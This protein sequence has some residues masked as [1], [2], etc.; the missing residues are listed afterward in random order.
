MKQ[1]L[2]NLNRDRTSWGQVWMDSRIGEMDWNCEES[3]GRIGRDTSFHRKA[4]S[5]AVAAVRKVVDR[6]H[7]L[8]A[9]A[10]EGIPSQSHSSAPSPVVRTDSRVQNPNLSARI[11]SVQPGPHLPTVSYRH[12]AVVFAEKREL[13]QHRGILSC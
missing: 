9:A 4:D 2:R 1:P 3:K 5:A 13:V 8:A 6:T 10:A 7:T 12:I 11:P